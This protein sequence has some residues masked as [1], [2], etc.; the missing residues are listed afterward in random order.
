MVLK[1][2]YDTVKVQSHILRHKDHVAKNKSSKWCHKIFPFSSPSLIKIL[3]A[4]LATAQLRW[5]LRGTAI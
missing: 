1:I 4:L 5:Q 3:V 2:D